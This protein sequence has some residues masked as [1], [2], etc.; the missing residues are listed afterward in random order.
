MPVP[1]ELSLV[2]W[3]RS[4]ATTRSQERFSEHKPLGFLPTTCRV[5]VIRTLGVTVH[6]VTEEYDAGPVVAQ[7][8]VPVEPTDTP[9]TLGERVQERER[10]PLLEV[11]GRLAEG[12]LTL[13]PGGE[14]NHPTTPFSGP[15]SR[16]AESQR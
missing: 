4:S 3:W 10:T 1:P 12:R 9:E 16:V 15:A 13:P 11:L 6:V 5:E 8:E 14:E 7:C 2:R